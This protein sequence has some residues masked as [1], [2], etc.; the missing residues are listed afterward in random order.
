MPSPYATGESKCYW[1]SDISPSSTSVPSYSCRFRQPEDNLTVILYVTALAAFLTVPLAIFVEWLVMNV[2]V[3]PTKSSSIVAVEISPKK[4]QSLIKKSKQ[5][6]EESKA[7]LE[8]GLRRHR[9]TLT[10]DKLSKFDGNLF[11]LSLLFL[12]SV[13]C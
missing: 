9:E 5:S 13:A 10:G 7:K 12:Y 4:R 11:L 8:M 6:I 1:A 2:L 3:A